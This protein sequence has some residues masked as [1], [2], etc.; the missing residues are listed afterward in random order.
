MGDFEEP[1][2]TEVLVIG[3]GIAGGTAALDLADAGFEVLVATRADDLMESNTQLA[4]GG[5]VYDSRGLAKEIMA[6]GCYLNN[7][8]AVRILAK[9]G[10]DRVNHTLIHR[11]DVEF[12]LKS[13]VLERVK[14]GGHS[15]ARI[16][17]R[18]DATGQ[19]IQSK[20]AKAMLEHPNIRVLLNATA[21]DLLTPSHHSA[22]RLA[23]Y[24]PL[25][26]VGAY[27]LNRQTGD[28]VRCLAKQTVL[29]TGGL[30]QI[31]E[32]TTNPEGAR[33]DGIAMA[34]RAEA[35]VANLQFVQF[36]PTAFYRIG[37]PRKLISEACRGAGAKVVDASGNPVL[38]KY[39]ERADLATRDIVARAMWREMISTRVPSLYLNFRDYIPREKILDYFPTIR[40]ML[41]D[42]GV[43]ILTD[44]VPV[45][46]AAHYSCGGVLAKPETAETSL[47][48]LY[49]IGEVA[50]NGLHG[51]NRLASTSLLEGLVFGHRAARTIESRLT[52]KPAF[53]LSVKPWQNAADEPAD[54]ALIAEDLRT[55][56]G[57]MWNYVGLE[58]TTRRLA[59]A[60]MELGRAERTVEN[61]YQSAGV[62][63][64]LI[65][66]RNT[67]RTAVLV[68]EAAWIDRQSAGCHYRT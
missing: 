9:E 68:A 56:R 66:L 44:L 34:H 58:R 4:Q 45:V 12:D 29:A 46:P 5:I 1:I 55:I 39:D 19:A 67:A 64:S 30:G 10:P 3:G 57:I 37:A 62:T 35:R 59:R 65:G 33:G 21:V 54:E 51:A 15:V 48:N 52:K 26:V 40:E 2:R 14:E 17:H 41:L 8:A 42:Y 18:A 28:I 23:V 47:K 22:D 49:A 63:D 6:A 16:V 32:H 60:R 20:F 36:H 24:R 50:C 11:L 43:D 13:G 31:Y 7:P 38:K 53:D 27:L 25:T 61:F